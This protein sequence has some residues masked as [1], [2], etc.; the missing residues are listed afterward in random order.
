MQFKTFIYVV[1]FILLGTISACTSEGDQKAM[2]AMADL[3]HAERV[4]IGT[5]KGIGSLKGNFKTVTLKGGDILNNAAIADE[6]ITAMGALAFMDVWASKDQK[7]FNGFKI[8]LERSLNGQLKKVEAA[9]AIDTLNMVKKN[10]QTC[11][12]AGNAMVSKEYAI[13]YNQL[14]FDIKA[15]LNVEKFSQEMRQIDSAYGAISA[16]KVTNFSTYNATQN[17]GSELPI[18]NYTMEV[19]RDS[20]ISNIRFKYNLLKKEAGL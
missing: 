13:L 1:G 17:D 2:T 8:K 6:N 12:K 16:F 20:V 10:I 3:F 19:Q 18:V 11:I 14:Y 4:A 9:Y 15:Q 5:E 7:D